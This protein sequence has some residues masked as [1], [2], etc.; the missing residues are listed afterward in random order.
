MSKY[1]TTTD[2]FAQISVKNYRN[3]ARNPYAQYQQERTLEQVKSS[4]KIHGVLTLLQCS[5]TTDGAACI[6]L[7]SENVVKK[8]NLEA[9]AVE[10]VASALTTDGEKA[11]DNNIELAGYSMARNAAEKVYKQAGVRPD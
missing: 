6:I 4:R 2:Q 11:W 1:G 8:H 7:C 10:I 9:Q 3:G 5:P